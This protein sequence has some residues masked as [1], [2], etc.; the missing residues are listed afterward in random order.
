[1]G[2]AKSKVSR[3][4]P[5]SG[6]KSFHQEGKGNLE[7]EEPKDKNNDPEVK[8]KPKD[9][10]NDREVKPKLKKEAVKETKEKE[11]K[12]K[13]N[14]GEKETQDLVKTVKPAKEKEQEPKERIQKWCDR[15]SG[16]VSLTLP[17]NDQ[18]LAFLG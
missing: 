3:N 17:L 6:K 13:K 1:M 11:D 9:R 5:K 15:I 7:V 4:K 8:P 12:E 14:D 16:M 2:G 10:S 18:P